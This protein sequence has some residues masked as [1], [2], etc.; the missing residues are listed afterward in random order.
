MNGELLLDIHTIILIRQSITI[1]T[2]GSLLDSTF[3]WFNLCLIKFIK[4]AYNII[5]LGRYA[6]YLSAL[7]KISCIVFYF[8]CSVIS[9]TDRKWNNKIVG[10]H[11]LSLW[12]IKTRNNS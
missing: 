4:D 8:I 6:S 3:N 7:T 11:S 2:T 1:Y 10:S 12:Y 5:L 9:F